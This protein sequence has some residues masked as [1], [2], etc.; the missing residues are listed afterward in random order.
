MTGISI[1]EPHEPDGTEDLAV[2]AWECPCGYFKM[3]LTPVD[4]AFR[5][6]HFVQCPRCGRK[7]EVLM[8]EPK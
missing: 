5:V 8:E 2:G 7:A 6:D 1:G 4:I 3:S